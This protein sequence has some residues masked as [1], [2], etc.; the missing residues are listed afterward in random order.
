MHHECEDGI[1]KSVPRITDWHHEACLVMTIGDPRDRFFYPIS[2]W[3]L[4]SFFCASLNTPF[5]IGK[6][7][8]KTSRKSWIQWNAIWW[9]IFNITMTTRIDVRPTWGRRATV[10]F[11]IFPTGRYGHPLNLN[12]LFVILNKVSRIFIWTMLWFKQ[13]KPLKCVNWLFAY[14]K[15]GNFNIHIWVWFGYFIC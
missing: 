8:K 13:I 10:R 11:F 7:W 5:Y 4:D 3:I 1:E 14:C 6:T 12:L 15:G 9:F 2:T